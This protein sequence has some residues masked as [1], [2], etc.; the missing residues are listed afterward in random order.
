MADGQRHLLAISHTPYAT[1]R[2]SWPKAAPWSVNRHSSCRTCRKSTSSNWRRSRSC[3]S[4]SFEESRPPPPT[5]GLPKWS[6]QRIA[7][8]KRHSPQLRLLFV[9]PETQ[10]GIAATPVIRRS[11]DSDDSSCGRLPPRPLGQRDWPSIQSVRICEICVRTLPTGRAAP[12]GGLVHRFAQ[13][14][15]DLHRFAQI[16]TDLHRFQSLGG[17]DSAGFSRRS[18]G[19]RGGGIRMN[20]ASEILSAHADLNGLQYR[21]WMPPRVDIPRAEP[22]APK[23][24]QPHS[25]NGLPGYLGKG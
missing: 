12:K 8:R 1:R 4:E 20:W 13:I 2:L 17:G 3:N 10:R 18:V 6:T 5:P 11:P 7:T 22:A 14:C 9:P 16:C 23:K 24:K 25:H 19:R 21:G 15:T